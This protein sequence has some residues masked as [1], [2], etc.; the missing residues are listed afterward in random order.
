M[1]AFLNE[2]FKKNVN[3]EIKQRNKKKKH[4]DKYLSDTFGIHLNNT[5]LR[6]SNLT[7]DDCKNQ[8]SESFTS[9]YPISNSLS[10]LEQNHNL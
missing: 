10:L 4:W 9:L 7:C 2:E 5:L 8:N 3:N 6:L 1:N